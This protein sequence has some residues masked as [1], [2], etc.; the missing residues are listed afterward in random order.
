[1]SDAATPADRRPPLWRNPFAIGFVVG[2][3]VLTVL[4]FIQRQS[5]KA[6]P[7]ITSVGAFQLTDEGGLAFSSA[8]LKGKV[9]IANFFFARCPS[10][11]PKMQSETAKI[12]PHVEDLGDDDG[13]APVLLVSFTVDPEHDTPEVLAAYAR[14][15]QAPAGRWKFLTGDRELIKEIAVK[16]FLLG[17]G[18]REAVGGDV[19]D[20][21]HSGKLAL[22]DQNGDVR[23]YWDLD[24]GGRSAIISA[25]RLLAKY[26]PNP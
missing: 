7:P 9:W 2:A 26:G 23:G 15:L 4:P 11:C 21:V 19:Y 17:M 1:M 20:V 6:P 24:E 14:K 3:I 12:L 10:I 22:V 8:D 5:L 25:A 13:E 18:D 16:R